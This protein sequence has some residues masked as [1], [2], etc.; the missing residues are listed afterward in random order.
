MT[1]TYFHVASSGMIAEHSHSLL[2]VLAIGRVLVPFQYIQK[3]S[4]VELFHHVGD[5]SSRKISSK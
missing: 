2:V 3:Q 1:G 4:M 5:L